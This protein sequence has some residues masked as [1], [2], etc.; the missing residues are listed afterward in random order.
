MVVSRVIVS[1]RIRSCSVSCG[2]GGAGEAD[3][4]GIVFASGELA[5]R[6]IEFKVLMQVDAWW[7][8]VRKSSMDA[9]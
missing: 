2:V 5:A 8:A 9:A 7:S 3:E 6:D 4:E 1:I